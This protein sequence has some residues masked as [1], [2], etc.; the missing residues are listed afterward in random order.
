[1]Y[2]IDYIDLYIDLYISSLFSLLPF[3]IVLVPPTSARD[4][5]GAFVAWPQG[6][7]SKKR[8]P[9]FVGFV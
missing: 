8:C 9:S 6:T 5:P 1:M 4:T 3:P 2:L 7:K